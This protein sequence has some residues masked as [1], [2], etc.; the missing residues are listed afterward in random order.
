VR[1]LER[2]A[3][4]LSAPE[5]IEEGGALRRLAASV[6]HDALELYGADY[7]EPDSE[8]DAVAVQ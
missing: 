8:A 7:A 2:Q 4:G 1:I 3:Q 5:I 6:L